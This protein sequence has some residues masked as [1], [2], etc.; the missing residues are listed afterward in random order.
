MGFICG[1]VNPDDTLKPNEHREALGASLTAV[2]GSLNPS[3]VSLDEIRQNRA[4]SCFNKFQL[5][6]NIH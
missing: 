2:V 1:F 3:S 6:I 4:I 5:T